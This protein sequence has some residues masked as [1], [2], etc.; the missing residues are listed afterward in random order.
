[1]QKQDVQIQYDVRCSW[2]GPPPNYRVWVDNELFVERTWIWVD[3]Y[4][5]EIIPICAP[6]GDYVIRYEVAGSARISF[7]NP[8]ILTGPGEFIADNIV[9]IKHAPA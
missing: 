5:E 1:M 6:P 9:R 4:L 8:K 3:H 2:E 7:G